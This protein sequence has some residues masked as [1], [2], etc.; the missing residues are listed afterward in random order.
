VKRKPVRQPTGPR[1]SWRWALAGMV[2][3]ALVVLVGVNLWLSSQPPRP[4]DAALR[5]DI[6]SG[7]SGAEVT[8]VG[9]VLSA[10]VKEPGHEK[11]EVQD[12]LGDQ[13][14]LDYNIS[15]GQWIP[16]KAGDRLTIRGQLYLDG[17][18]AGVHCLHSKTS[19][20]CPLPGWVEF[21][22]TTY[23]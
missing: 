11:I 19:S 22:G 2:A 17:G 23:S 4:D 14:E 18:R 13:L 5:A 1:W 3:A 10:P 21:D 12:Q 8:F 16:A 7:R 20:G 9:T 6:A 15:L